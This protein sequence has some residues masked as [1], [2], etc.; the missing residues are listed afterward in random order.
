MKN[1]FRDVFLVAAKR[2]PVGAFQGSLSSVSATT[3]G[4]EVVKAILEET[5]ISL[6]SVDEVIMG[7]VLSAG[8]GQATGPGPSGC[9]TIGSLEFC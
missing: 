1:T 2:T 8:L 3:L 5:K 9:F 4:S 6:D 7:C